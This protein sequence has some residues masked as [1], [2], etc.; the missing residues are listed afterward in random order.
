MDTRLLGW[1]EKFDDDALLISMDSDVNKESY[2]CLIDEALAGPQLL[3]TGGLLLLE[4]TRLLLEPDVPASER[5]A[6]DGG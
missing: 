2:R 3:A 6:E 1:F 5:A 4:I